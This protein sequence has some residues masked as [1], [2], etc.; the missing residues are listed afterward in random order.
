[1][2][3]QELTFTSQ[4]TSC[5]AWLYQPDG[6]PP[7]P[8]V[9]MAHG[10]SATRELALDAYA[11]RFAAAGLGVLLFDY[12]HFGASDGSPRQLLDINRQLADWHAAIAT[13]RDTPW[14]DPA[15]IAL[16]GS[17][18]SG[19][20]VVA[21]AAQDRH[22][23]AIAAQ[24]PFADGLATL[25][26]IGFGDALVLTA[27]A[28]RD[29]FGSLLGRDPH[30]IPAVAEPGQVGMM[31]T[32]DAKPGM[33]ALVPEGSLWQ[34]RVAAR[35]GL[36][37]PLYRPGT[38][39]KH[40]ACPALWCITDNDTLCP[41]ENAVAWARTAPRAEIKRYPIGHFDIYAGEHFERAVTDQT[42]FFTR[43]LLTP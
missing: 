30:Y 10:F 25:R 9:V 34:N 33:E 27:H 40:V 1:M 19:G 28:L 23:A 29:Q 17:S 13:A 18:Y 6:E 2:D 37:V 32:A 3:R 7:H 31:T 35:I 14:A 16:F 4:G 42:E 8:L 41:A 15:R 43:Q 39:A 21:V 5:A 36:W 11:E 20:H 12:R 24:C 38:K 22:V 26:T